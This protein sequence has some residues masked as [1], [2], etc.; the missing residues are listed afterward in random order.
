MKT[1]T[2]KAQSDSTTNKLR[3]CESTSRTTFML[4]VSRC[5]SYLLLACGHV[6]NSLLNLAAIARRIMRTFQSASQPLLPLILLIRNRRKLTGVI[7]F[8][9]AIAS[10]FFHRLFFNMYEEPHDVCGVIGF[11]GQCYNRADDTG[12][13]YT[14]WYWYWYEVKY[15]I[16]AI[17]GSVAL[18]LIIPAER[19]LSFIISSMLHAWGWMFFLH[20]TFFSTSHETINAVPSWQIIFIGAAL[21]VGIIMSADHLMYWFNHKALGNWQRFVGVTEMKGLT[22]EQKEPMYQQLAK[23]YRDVQ[24]QF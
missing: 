15:C 20:Y 4:L 11:S 17:F 7:L 10:I 19:S 12:W 16:A 23:D 22:P 18:V 6:R 9:V 24:K 2:L 1:Q 13:C 5:C 21:G 3:R 8:L 14:S